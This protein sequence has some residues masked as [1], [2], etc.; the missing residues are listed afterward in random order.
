MHT[1]APSKNHGGPK[2]ESDEDLVTSMSLDSQHPFLFSSPA[3][4]QAQDSTHNP[5]WSINTFLSSTWC[6]TL[7]TDQLPK[8]DQ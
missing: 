3:R 6:D 4:T 5:G 8:I 2:G 7:R 1:E